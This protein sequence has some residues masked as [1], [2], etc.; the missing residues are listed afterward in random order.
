MEMKPVESS[1][2]AAIGYADNTLTVRFR[3]GSEYEY[4]GVTQQQYE[5]LMAAPSKGK[6]IQG[7]VALRA[8]VVL[9]RSSKDLC[10]TLDARI[11]AGKPMH[12]TQA[13]GCCGKHLNKASLSGNLDNLSPFTC[14]K[15]GTVYNPKA[16]GP[17]VN[18]EA[19]AAVLV[20]KV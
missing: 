9:K 15:C 11:Y 12:T 20:F 16:Y 18:W 14:P 10:D 6:A 7:L 4:P 5:D 19:E 8:G 1:N 3:N 2:V 13:D 17:L